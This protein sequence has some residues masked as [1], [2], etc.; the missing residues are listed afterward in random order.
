[1]DTLSLVGLIAATALGLSFG[2]MLGTTVSLREHDKRIGELEDFVKSS[3]EHLSDAAKLPVVIFVVATLLCSCGA[4]FER[5]QNSFE[6]YKT[7]TNNEYIG[8]TIYDM[9]CINVLTND[10]WTHTKM[11]V[12]VIDSCEYFVSR[13]AHF[14]CH[15]ADCKHC[16]EIRQREIKQAVREVLHEQNTYNY[17]ESNN[18]HDVSD[19]W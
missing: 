10:F 17:G 1:M 11:T 14:V 16:A 15:K 18:T 9:Y 13:D 8:D 7:T 2:G 5:S 19:L 3:K 12:V 4:D 6:K